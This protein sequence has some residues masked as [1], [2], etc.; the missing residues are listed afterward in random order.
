MKLG[1]NV[2]DI[3]GLWNYME[4]MSVE[5]LVGFFQA[6]HGKF[7]FVSRGCTQTHYEL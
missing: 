1:S 6:R 3:G 7:W 5:D 4:E 2:V